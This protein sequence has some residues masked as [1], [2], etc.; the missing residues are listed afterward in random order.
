MKYKISGLKDNRGAATLAMAALLLGLIAM[1]VVFTSQMEINNNKITGNDFLLAQAE[2]AAIAGINDTLSD[3]TQSNVSNSYTLSN[4]LYASDGTTIVGCYATSITKKTVETINALER[5]NSAEIISKGYSGNGNH[6]AGNC[7][8]SGV[9]TKSLTQRL[10]FSNPLSSYFLNYIDAAVIS[11][12]ATNIDNT[13]LTTKFLD[14][15]TNLIKA[16]SRDNIRCN[17]GNCTDDYIMEQRTDI[18]TDSF[19]YVF[20]V[21]KNSGGANQGKNLIKS[22][23]HYKSCTGACTNPS[24]F[25]NTTAHGR[26]LWVEVN[27][28]GSFTLDNQTVGQE[29]NPVIMVVV[30]NGTF[31]IKNNSTIW[32]MVYVMGD[33]NNSTDTG[34]INGPLVVDGQLTATRVSVNY[35]MKK[36]QNIAR[37]GFF[38]PKP[39]SWNDL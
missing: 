28:G 31:R 29:N 2:A 25:T 24:E 37:V 13:R 3:M 26:I 34:T 9:A 20:G 8:T 16:K 5:T 36:A 11:T 10:D 19:P 23:G 27:A 18:A 14:G 15:A 30:N 12:G 21:G 6:T 1:S 33:W 7:S 4:V 22:F 35:N 17:G 38:T 32:G 39:A